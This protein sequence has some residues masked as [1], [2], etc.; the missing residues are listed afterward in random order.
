MIAL[1]AAVLRVGWIAYVNVSPLDG[2]FDDTVF[3]YA[4]ARFLASG[5]GY[6]VY[7]HE[8]YTASWPP[9]YPL[10][11][12]VP[13]AVFGQN[14]LAAKLPNVALGVVSCLLTYVVGARV[15]GRRCGLIAAFVLAIFPGQIYF[16][17]LV[18]TETFFGTIF[19]LIALLV[20][21]WTLDQ[22]EASRGQ[23]LALGVLAGFAMLV[24][25]EAMALAPAIVLLWRFVLPNGRQ[26]LRYG[27]LFA[28]GAALLPAAWTARN[29]VRFGEFIPIRETAPGNFAYIFDPGYFEDDRF[30]SPPP[31]LSETLPPM[32]RRPWKMAPIQLEKLHQLYDNDSDGVWWV[33]NNRPPLDAAVADR[34]SK[35]GSYFFFSVAACAVPAMAYG[36]SLR[37]RRRF[38]LVY[39]VLVWTSIHTVLWPESRYHFPVAPLLCIF[40]AAT[41]IAL[42]DQ[43]P[44]RLRDRAGQGG[45]T[46]ISDS[47]R[48]AG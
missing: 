48:L 37:D 45:A 7:Y 27:V 36:L 29:Y 13:F 8:T 21:M 16:S 44:A 32:L 39:L 31:K 28:A 23:L 3:Y 40:A 43:I 5:D 15:F 19:I 18:M 24:R 22:P 47:P 34:W 6:R 17:T 14:L 33:Q 41:L 11:V 38:A 20:V 42:W 2:R 46:G 10:F 26:V 4:A 25:A 9:G 35:L 1:I 12:A 30:V